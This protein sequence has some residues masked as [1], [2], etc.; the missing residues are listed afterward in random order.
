MKIPILEG[1]I[2]CLRSVEPEKDYKQWYEVMKD[3]DM[4]HWTGNT[5]PKDSNEIKD[6]LHTYKNLK[7]YY[8]LGNCN[9][10]IKGNDR[11]IL[12]FYANGE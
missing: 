12:D 1:D 4:H 9:E 6:L 8:G 10:K 3:P 5:I 11:D 2:V 7:R